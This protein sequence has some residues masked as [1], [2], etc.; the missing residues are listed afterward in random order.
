[1]VYLPWQVEATASHLVTG[2]FTRLPNEFPKM[3][4]CAWGRSLVDAAGGE[5]HP[6]LF[7]DLEG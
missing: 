6:F 7:F 4:V 5:C 3:S 1:M 2:V